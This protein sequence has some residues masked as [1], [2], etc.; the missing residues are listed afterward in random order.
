MTV[1]LCIGIAVRDVVLSVGRLPDP[2]TK[3]FARELSESIGGPAATAAVTI[4]RLGGT[5][6][7]AGRVGSDLHGRE[8]IEALVAE[9]VDVSSV[10]IRQGLTTPLS[11]VLVTPDGERTIVN[12]RPPE[13]F[14]DPAVR[15]TPD[16]DAVL[17]DV[18]WAAA[19]AAGFDAAVDRATPRILDLDRFDEAERDAVAVAT[20]DASH[21][22]ASHGGAAQMTGEDDPIR[23]LTALEGM[24]SG[25]VAVTVG[26]DGVWWNDG[27]EP[28][29]LPA[30]AISPVETLGAGDVFHGAAALAVAEGATMEAALRFASA[31]AALRCTLTGGWAAIPDRTAVERLVED[32]WN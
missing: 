12:H 5:A 30:P 6:R 15:V 31:A 25:R 4:A 16:V 23:A 29:R 21:V 7:F 3:S 32:T 17:G 28:R 10:S 2:G 13:L 1:V 14:A 18:R 8:V 24:T 22:L 11:A 20:G 27:G 19:T 9:H 26:A